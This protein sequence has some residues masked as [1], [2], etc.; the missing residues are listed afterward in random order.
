MHFSPREDT[1][2]ERK[3]R[4]CKSLFNYDN[5]LVRVKNV[6]HKSKLYIVMRNAKNKSLKH[7]LDI[8][9]KQKHV[10]YPVPFSLDGHVTSVT[11][12][13]KT[14]HGTHWLCFPAPFTCLPGTMKS[15]RFHEEHSIGDDLRSKAW[16]AAKDA[17]DNVGADNVAAAA[18]QTD[19]EQLSVTCGCDETIADPRA[20]VEGGG[21]TFAKLHGEGRVSNA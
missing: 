16:S 2:T 3:V 10:N 13:Y 20:T 12:G 14:A 9:Q 21:N 8:K 5:L 19:D 4:N 17:A 11:C 18:K 6:S 1:W 7:K 15:A